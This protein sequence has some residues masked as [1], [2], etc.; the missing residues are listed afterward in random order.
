[1]LNLNKLSQESQWPKSNDGQKV[2]TESRSVGLSHVVT[3]P[4]SE[5]RLS[6]DEQNSSRCSDI[7]AYK[8]WHVVSVNSWR[9]YKSAA[10]P[11]V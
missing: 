2:N 3:V 9:E 1:M 10:E 7:Q 8:A 11:E 4:L 5:S 6:H